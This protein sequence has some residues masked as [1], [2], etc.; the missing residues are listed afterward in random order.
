MRKKTILPDNH[1]DMGPFYGK[2]FTM[3]ETTVK[4]IVINQRDGN[5]TT[6]VNVQSLMRHQ[7]GSMGYNELQNLYEGMGIHDKDADRS[8]YIP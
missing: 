5:N 2:Y 1:V 7:D 8:T 4:T 3:D 6:N